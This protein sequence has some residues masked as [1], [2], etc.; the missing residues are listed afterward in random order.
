MLYPIPGASNVPDNAPYLI[1]GQVLNGGA[2]YTLTSP[3]AS[4]ITASTTVAVP[5]P[6]PT[7]IALGSPAAAVALPALAAHAT[8]TVTSSNSGPVTAC[9]SGQPGGNL[10]TFTTH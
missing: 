2:T 8:Y 3:T 10:G 5:S 1:I 6:L 9:S 7:P 4:T